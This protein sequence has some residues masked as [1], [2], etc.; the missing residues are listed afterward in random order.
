VPNNDLFLFQEKRIG[1]WI[2]ARSDF[3]AMPRENPCAQCGQ[4]IGVPEWIESEAGR[5][6]YLW[7]CLVCDYRFEAVAILNDADPDA[8]DALAA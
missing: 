7:H 1:R 5:T 2:M 3:G 8:P 6:H 4:P